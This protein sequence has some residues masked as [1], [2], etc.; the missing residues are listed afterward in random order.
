LEVFRFARRKAAAQGLKGKVPN[1]AGSRRPSLPFVPALFL[2]GKKLRAPP[3]VNL[4]AV[5]DI[6]QRMP[7]RRHSFGTS[8]LVTCSC[9]VEGE[10]K[11]TKC[12]FE[13]GPSY[14]GSLRVPLKRKARAVLPSVE[15]V[16]PGCWLVKIVEPAIMPTRNAPAKISIIWPTGCGEGWNRLICRSNSSRSRWFICTSTPASLPCEFTSRRS[17]PSFRGG[18]SGKKKTFLGLP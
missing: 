2:S 1:D 12:R 8:W 13:L 5:T 15:A 3:T 18:I 4:K 17:V 9:L 11:L 6:P 7:W 10:R 16:C 14:R